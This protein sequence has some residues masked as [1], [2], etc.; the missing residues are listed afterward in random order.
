MSS[1]STTSSAPAKPTLPTIE[2]TIRQRHVLSSIAT[3]RETRSYGPTM[4][5]LANSV[6]IRAQS[7]VIIHVRRL[8]NLGLLKIEYRNGQMIG[9]SIQ[10]TPQGQAALA[11]ASDCPQ[12]LA[13]RTDAK[14]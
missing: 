5:E 6:G 11:V 2:L 10:L 13:V 3:Y 4:R 1:P 12:T 7:A 8:A 9:R 14:F